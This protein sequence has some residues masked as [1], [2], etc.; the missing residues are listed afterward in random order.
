MDEINLKNA[1]NSPK[2]TRKEKIL[3]ILYSDKKSTKKVKTIKT[4]GLENGLRKISSWNVSQILIDLN[5]KAFKLSDGW[6]ISEDGI[7]NINE[8]GLLNISPISQ[9]RIDLRKQLSVIQSDEI[10]YFLEETIEALE[11][12]LLRSAVVL[13]WIGCISIL[14]KFVIDN[15]LIDFNKEAKRRNNNWKNAK[16]LDDLSVMK[17]YDFLQVLQSISVIGKNIKQELEICLKFR[18]ACG[19]PNSLKIGENRVAAHLE[20]LL[21]NIYSKYSI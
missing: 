8:L 19:H 7:N 13:S 10:K 11:R 4:I 21:L 20:T 16:T 1:L 14:Q 18:N 15:H 12:K 6:E 17:E 3:C 5:E 2:L 9:P